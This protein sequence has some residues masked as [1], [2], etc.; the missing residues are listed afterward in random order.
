MKKLTIITALAAAGI[1]SVASAHY[2]GYAID[3]IGKLV[4]DS[5]GNC[6]KTGTWTKEK[7][8]A[9]CDPKL[10]QEVKPQLQNQG[11]IPVA[12][13]VASPEPEPVI[14]NVMEESIPEI[15]KLTEL[16]QSI[17]EI[18]PFEETSS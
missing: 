13:R 11:T 6:M 16:E 9:Q 10:I 12:P 5:F 18:L 8:I 1:I 2:E 4:R 7:A 14:P 3:S 17:P 15:K